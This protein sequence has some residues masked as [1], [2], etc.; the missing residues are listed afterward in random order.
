MLAIFQGVVMKSDKEILHDVIA[1]LD[2]DASID[3]SKIGVTA[4]QGVI[5]L[6]GHVSTHSDRHAAESL[7]KRVHGVQA[8]ANEIEVRPRGSHQRDDEQI[9]VAAV[10]SLEW[11]GKVPK[12]R[13]QVVVS[14]G[15]ITL[16][17]TTE[18]RFEKEAAQRAIRHLIGVR[19]VTNN[20]VVEPVHTTVAE[21][22]TRDPIKDAIESALRRSALVSSKQIDIEVNQDTVVLS[23]DVRSQA[24]RDEVERIAWMARAISQV[25]NCITITPWGCGPMEEWG[26]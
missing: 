21:H 3:E 4:S 26:Y 13:V 6:S 12:D 23:G 1:E 24:E 22:K 17:G 14:D 10:H 15:T 5:T 18:H 8:I 16:E 11:D 2:W 7:A 20:I 9:A 25:D 19:G